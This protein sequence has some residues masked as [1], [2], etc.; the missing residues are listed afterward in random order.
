MIK[1]D[2]LRQ[3]YIK[4]MS[5]IEAECF[6]DPWSEEMLSGELSN[7]LAFYILALDGEKVVGYAGMHAVL[8]EAYITNVAV[9]GEHRRQGIARELLNQLIGECR[10]RGI[11]YITLEV[12]ESNLGAQALYEGMG[13]EV[14][15]RRVRY[16]GGIEDALIMSRYG[17]LG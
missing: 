8:D 10:D 16:Y 11:D 5:E 4:D 17:L 3:K 13:F 9:R 15:G 1:Y 12:R 2:V 14:C 7:P 6:D